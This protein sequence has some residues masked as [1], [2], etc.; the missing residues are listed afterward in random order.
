MRLAR[1]LIPVALLGLSGPTSP[2]QLDTPHPTRDAAAVIGV[3]DGVARFRI[4]P[5]DDGRLVVIIS[6]LGNSRTSYPVSISLAQRPGP[7]TLSVSPPLVAITPYWP[8]PDPRPVADHL[9]IPVAATI[10]RDGPRRVFDVPLLNG[11]PLNNGGSVRVLARPAAEGQRSIVYLDEAAGDE[12]RHFEL[13]A[14][15]VGLLESSIMPDGDRE[16]GLPAD[17][18][19]DGRLAILLTPR[20]AYL[21]DGRTT[22]GGFV[23]AADFRPQLQRPHS[24]Q[25]DMIYLNTSL[26]VGQRLTDVLSH[27]YRHVLAF[28]H[29]D[30]LGRDAEEDWLNEAMAH[31]A[32]PGSTNISHRVR[33]YLA[34]SSR[35]PLVVP[36]YY[37]AGLWRC[38]G[39]RGSTYLFLDWC[40]QQHGG[41]LVAQML[42]SPKTGIDNLVA[43]TRTPFPRLFRRWSVSL[44]YTHR[45]RRRWGPTMVPWDGGGTLTIH[46]AG[47]ATAYIS[48]RQLPAGAMV[49]IEAPSD[50]R[51]QVTAALRPATGWFPRPSTSAAP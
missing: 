6:A 39:V 21:Q 4:S 27:E 26:P 7:A 11:R 43:V 15:I 18:D 5:D 37:H 19:G 36:D 17:I 44:L 51:L 9:V 50:A 48:P 33:A 22:V 24:N 13:A 28:S 45:S 23:R 49:R 25:A 35:F 42:R 2:P 14:A 46:L 3:R 12:P 47:T 32:E 38:D 41:Q 29:R 40:R 1:W 20:L 34:D 10:P 16:I 8:R 31:L 30:A